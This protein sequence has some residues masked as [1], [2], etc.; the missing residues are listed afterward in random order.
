MVREYYVYDK[1]MTQAGDTVVIE[2]ADGVRVVR[3]SP[4]QA[5]WFIDQG[6]IGTINKN[7]KPAPTT[8]PTKKIKPR[9][10]PTMPGPL[11]AR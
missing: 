2:N 1:T 8:A 9:G 5:K 7:T 10:V 6:V 11:V 4:H 3:L